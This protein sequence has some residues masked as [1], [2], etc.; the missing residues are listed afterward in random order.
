FLS[1]CSAG[2]RL[3]FISNMSGRFSLYAMDQEGSVPEPLLP[4]DIALQN[5]VLLDGVPF[6]VFPRFDRILVMIDHDGDER[7]QPM[8]IPL[9]GG[10]PEPAFGASFPGQRLYSH[11]PDEEQGIVYLVAE[12]MHEQRYETHRAFIGSGR[13][14]RLAESRFGWIPTGS[15]HLHTKTVLVESYG[16]GDHVL[17]MHDQQLG[18]RVLAGTPIDAR[19]TG[20]TERP[21]GFGAACFTG[22]EAGVLVLTSLFSDFYGLAYLELDGSAR[23]TPVTIQDTVHHGVGEL[24]GIRQ[25]KGHR[26]CLH[27]NVDG[28]SWA[29]EGVFDVASHT[30]RLASVLAGKGDLSDGVV[31]SCHYSKEHDRFSLSFTTAT[32]PTQLCTMDRTRPDQM[33]VLTR[34]RI[35][36]IPREHLSRGEDASFVSHDGWRVSARLY[37]PAE[38]CGF[39]G[40]RPVVLYIHGGPQSQ[41]R[42]D[43]SWFSMPLIQFLSLNGFAVFVPNVRGST[44]YGLSYMRAVSRDW[45][46][47]DRLDHLFAMTEVLPADPR[48]DLSR[49]GVVGRSY[50]GY[51]ALL[52]A[53]RH[54]GLW[55]AAVD[56]FG[57]YDLVAF[58]N[59][60]PEAWKPHFARTVGDPATDRDFLIERSPRTYIGGLACPLLVIQGRNDPRVLEQESRELVGELR[61]RGRSVD[62]LVFEDEGHDVLKF[63]NRVRC[64]G[65]ITGF[66]AGH[67]RP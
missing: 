18:F 7:Y 64:Y 1:P 61:D 40:P 23:P 62:Y 48:L 37:L 22:D 31:T 38:G 39:E 19:A 47:Q 33:R 12:S 60:I 49:A 30:M 32:S 17:A 59:R 51:M 15:N 28:A 14:T 29:Y 43:F 56:M 46:G 25:V 13:V 66:F 52:L 45:G 8:A 26:F 41:E 65:A 42:P 63:A 67:L 34:E 6:A 53:A 57:P 27:Y 50:G 54:P 21:T 10:I 5:P 4:P 11:L 9:E 24:E 20:A 3:Y 35:L 44:G 2:G 55:K 58:S 16:D 36:G